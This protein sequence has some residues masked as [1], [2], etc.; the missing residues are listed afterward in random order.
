MEALS[1]DLERIQ[2]DHS[3][4]SEAKYVEVE[5]KMQDG[6]S[7]I[8][9]V[10]IDGVLYDVVRKH[11]CL[12][13]STHRDLEVVFGGEL[14]DEDGS[15]FGAEGFEDGATLSISWNESHMAMLVPP[16][17]SYDEGTTFATR[18]EG[19]GC[20]VR[21]LDPLGCAG[22]IA[23]EVEVF[24]EGVGH[25]GIELG[26]TTSELDFMSPNYNNSYA[27]LQNPSWVSS[28]AGCFWCHGDSDRNLSPN[29]GNWSSTTPNQLK[30]GDIVRCE[31]SAEGI[32]SI[33]VN[34][35]VQVKWDL[36]SDRQGIMLHGTSIALPCDQP[37]YAIIGL[38]APCKAVSVR[39]C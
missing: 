16:A 33:S 8:I 1:D 39:R 32:M 3:M 9:I 37:L 19:R 27:V 5:L 35:L 31:V 25:E 2:S 18:N 29:G 21:S 20:V 22:H 26:V 30:T 38:R 12:D 14:L 28:D 7:E 23:F 15:T 10:P 36:V 6:T 11:L 13:G 24:Y 17:A 34:D 4:Q